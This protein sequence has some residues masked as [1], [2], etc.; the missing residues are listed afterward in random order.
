MASRR[1]EAWNTAAVPARDRAG[2]WEEALA[3]THVAFTP[4]VPD[5]ERFAATAVRHRL[6]DLALVD[7]AVSPSSGT[8]GPREISVDPGWAGLL[9]VGSGRE[10]VRQ[11]GHEIVVGPGDAIVWDGDQPAEFEVLE[12]LRK[13]T[14]LLPRD[15]VLGLGGA[16]PVRVPVASPHSRLLRGFVDMLAAELPAL[17]S[18]AC[19]A[20]A[21]AALE[22][23]RAVL[24]PP[25]TDL[26]TQLLPAVRAFVDARLQDPDLAPRQIAAAHAISLRTLHALFEP[27]GETLGAYVRR[28]R[29]EHA[30]EDL[31]ARPGVPV[32]R[33]AA[34]WGFRSAAHFSR[35][36]RAA[37]G[38][39]P[40]DVREDRDARPGVTGP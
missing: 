3:A 22:L 21:N 2:C 5:P 12:P 35:S 20:A 4:R 33:V 40:R 34:R 13:R 25:E 6:G 37:Y 17:D 15:R 30:R 1:R 32:A 36:F 10:R 31:V 11:A 18:R 14:L 28:R 7:C 23:L 38:E 26:R 19:D 9:V 16:V 29:L 24:A 8:R 39:A 27:T